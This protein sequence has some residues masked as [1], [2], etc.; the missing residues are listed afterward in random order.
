MGKANAFQTRLKTLL[1][2]LLLGSG[3]VL[4]LPSQGYAQ[5]ALT[6]AVVESIRNRVE[7]LPQSQP[8]RPARISD[9]VAP[10]DGVAT[11]RDSLAELRFNDGSLGRIGEQAI[12]WFTP[13]TRD[14]RMSNGTVLLLIPPGQ[15]QTRVRTPNAAAGIRGSALFVR[16]IPETETTIIGALTDSGIEFFNQDGSRLQELRGGQM[17][18]ATADQIVNVYEFDLNRFY[19]TSDLM[20]GLTP[21]DMEGTLDRA[22]APVQAEM[23]ASLENQLPFA[24]A[25]TLTTPDFLRLP[26]RVSFNLTSTLDLSG[27]E[28]RVPSALTQPN[29]PINFNRLSEWT[30]NNARSFLQFRQM[31]DAP[32]D[33]PVIR[34]PENTVINYPNDLISPV[35]SPTLMMDREID[36]DRR[37]TGSNPSGGDRFG[38]DVADD[39]DDIIPN[40]D[41]DDDSG[42]PGMEDSPGMED[43][44][45]SDDMPMPDLPMDSPDR[46]NPGIGFGA[47][48]RPGAGDTPGEGVSDTPGRSNPG[49]GFGAGGRPNNE[50][51]SDNSDSDP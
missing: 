14:F 17:A 18:I 9:V 28:D 16:Y 7:L 46:D 47:G 22:I 37:N 6:Q 21:A 40:D 12:F 34:L 33:V 43:M 32:M 29:I 35:Q 31:N 38:D 36:T 25:D 44:P 45:D 49:I 20:R 51:A 15:G 41:F 10:G 23:R 1:F 50:E 13:G 48:G 2:A 24:N 39:P 27:V 8:A 5:T 4:N 3:S 26:N 42:N 11:A 30:S 19:E